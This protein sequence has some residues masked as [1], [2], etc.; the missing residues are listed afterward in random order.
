MSKNITRCKTDFNVCIPFT[1]TW[2]GV[3]LGKGKSLKDKGSIMNS[4]FQ[5]NVWIEQATPRIRIKNHVQTIMIR[6]NTPK[7]RRE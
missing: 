7:R 6:K 1:T 2:T 5:N 4:S 3:A